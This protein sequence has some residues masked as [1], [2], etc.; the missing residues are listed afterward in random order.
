MGKFLMITLLP[1]VIVGC[2]QE[3]PT[4]IPQNI[5]RATTDVQ[6]DN[7]QVSPMFMSQDR[8]LIGIEKKIGILGPKFIAGKGNKYMWHF[9]G[10]KDVLYSAK[11]KVVAINKETGEKVPAL[12]EN[13]GTVSE[14]KVWEYSGTG[15]PYN[16]ADAIMTS[17]MSLPK[18][19]I[20]RLD[21]YINDKFFASIVVEVQQ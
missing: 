17:N 5:E 18:Q 11:V 6:N 8:E 2:A 20:W 19:G 14:S 16:G 21:I 3:Q 9:W 10:D 15:G 13:T 12:I 7:W 4:Q 1:L